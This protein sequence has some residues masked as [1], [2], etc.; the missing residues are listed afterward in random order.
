MCR[1]HR[2]FSGLWTAPLQRFGTIDCLVNNA[3][4][5]PCT[6]FLELSE[7]EWDRVQGTNLKGPFLCSQ[8]VA[9]TMIS[10]GGPGEYCQCEFNC[11]FAG[12][13]RGCPLCILQGRFEYVDQGPGTGAGPERHQGKCRTAGID[14][15][16]ARSESI[17]RSGGPGRAPDK[18][19][20][21][22]IKA[23]G[24][25]RRTSSKR[26]CTSCRMRPAIPRGPF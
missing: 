14:F 8:A 13:T 4:V 25:T 18:T 15:N 24:A 1:N 12:P 3:G 10:Q 17:E 20:Q 2:M 6:P 5:Y 23:G 22:T 26:C 21:D 19:R 11:Q 16:R 7:Q 9:G